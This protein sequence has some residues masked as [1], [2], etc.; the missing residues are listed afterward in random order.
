M[1][2]QSAGV[3]VDDG[4][5]FIGV[6]W[7][8][9]TETG[10]YVA[11][12]ESLETPAQDGYYSDNG[13]AWASLS[14]ALSGYRSLMVRADGFSPADG[15]WEQVV[16]SIFG[17]GNG[18]GDPANTGASTMASFNGN[19][20]VGT[21]NQF[22]GEVEYT[23]D[24]ENWFLGNTPGFNDSTNDAVA[25]LIAFEGYLYA[26]TLNL[27]YGTQVWRATAPLAWTNVESNGFGDGSN[28]SAPSGAVFDG[29]LFLGT[30]HSG[31]CE[32]WR[33]PDGVVWSQ[34]HTNGFGNSQNRVAESMAVF[35]GELYA[36]TKNIG[37]AELW[38]SPD[39]FIW[40]PAM[41]GGF[42]S[43]ANDGDHR[44]RS[45]STVPSTRECR[46][47][48]LDAQLWRTPTGRPGRR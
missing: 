11:A 32:I 24:G 43:S 46:T 45:F 12:D 10:F 18:F 17:G 6:G 42:G 9:A 35:R 5:V 16:G 27:V 23:A 41:T 48:S 37:G 13:D 39:G 2:I 3:A 19:L 30:E 20:F 8:E 28:V 14:S 7:N 36:G 25:K 4:S 31:G 34:V 47:V 44:S 38:R 15:E 22:G 29:E 21:E 26:S 33:T 40:F 1:D